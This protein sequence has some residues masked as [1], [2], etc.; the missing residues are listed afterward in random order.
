MDLKD[1]VQL[2]RS[3]SG[4]RQAEL[5]LVGV[6]SADCHWSNFHVLCLIV[7]APLVQGEYGDCWNYEGEGTALN[8]Q[9]LQLW[10]FCY[11]KGF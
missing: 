10:I 9:Y 2:T 1:T 8:K 6:I 5:L 3:L 4:G 7:A 11:K